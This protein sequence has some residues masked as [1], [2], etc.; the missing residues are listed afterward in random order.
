MKVLATLFFLLSVLGMSAADFHIKGKVSGVEDGTHLYLRLVGPPSRDLDSLV[1]KD[2]VFEFRGEAPATPSWAT[3]SIEGKFVALSDFYLE[4]GSILIEGSRYQTSAKGTPANEV[5]SVYRNTLQPLYD[6]LGNLHSSFVSAETK[7]KKDMANSELKA[8][9]QQID[10][11]E[12]RFIRDYPSSVVALR[13]AGYKYNH[14]SASRINRM[15]AM[16]DSSLLK[17]PQ[18]VTIRQY[19]ASLSLSEEGAVASDFSLTTSSGTH[20]SLADR[21]GKYLLLDFWAS[22]CVPCRNSLPALAQLYEKYKNKNFEIVGISLDR[23]TEAWK[24][25]LS[26]ENCS[27]T[28]VCDPTGEVARKY[29]VSAIPLMMLVSPEGKI[30]KRFLQ[31]DELSDALARLFP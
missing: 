16:L 3:I 27:W 28:Q 18:A 10:E 5:Y 29:A 25:A 9:E 20:F 13:I 12:L 11:S 22:W 7:A 1:I 24:K 30:V 31:K 8:F 14:M 15:L 23:K 19:A 17:M 4:S 21:N 26:E 2:G 6:K